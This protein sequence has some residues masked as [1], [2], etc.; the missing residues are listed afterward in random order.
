NSTGDQTELQIIG[1]GIT[2]EGGGQLTLLENSVIVGTNPADTLTN[3]DNTISGAGEIGAGDGDLTLVNEVQGTIVAN[4]SGGTLILDTGNTIVNQGQL[5]ATNGGILQI[6]DPVAGGTAIVAGGTLE[7]AAQANVNV[8]FYNG[9]ATPVYGELVLG[10]ASDFSGQISGFV[11]TAPDSGHSDVVDL[12][13]FAFTATTFAEATTNGNLVITATD[14]S[15][16][17]SLTFANFD[18]T[19]D[20]GSDGHGG[21]L[22]T[23]PPLTG[24][25]NAVSALST[26]T[27]SATMDSVSDTISFAVS[28]TG[29]TFSVTE[30]AD[31]NGGVSVG[32]DFTANNDQID[33]KSG[34]VMTQSY[35]V[36]LSDAHTATQSTAQTVSVTIGGLGNDNFVFAPGI[37]VD[38]VTNFNPQQDTIELDHFANPQTVQELQALV[39][40]DVHGDALIN[41]GHNDSITFGN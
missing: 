22:I 10:D 4:V 3:V 13:G 21:T 29:D 19:L 12:S 24:S 30:P 34:E 25:A 20:F 23:D 7:F 18:A 1:S 39:S 40:S 16:V 26:I 28:H 38:A 2:L 6:D 33:L 5:E 35:N 11:G 14:G 27:S 37:G 32:F 15:S 31:A 8:V 9:T 17:A 41:L 36:A